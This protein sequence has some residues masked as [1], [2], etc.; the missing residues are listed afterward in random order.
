MEDDKQFTGLKKVNNFILF[1]ELGRGAYGEVF[2]STDEHLDE[3]TE[4][5]VNNRQKLTP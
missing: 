4:V 1:K 2:L 5:K 3:L